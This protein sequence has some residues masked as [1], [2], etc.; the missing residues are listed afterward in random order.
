MLQMPRVYKFISVFVFVSLFF[1]SQRSY[2]DNV[3]DLEVL[4]RAIDFIQGGPSGAV[5]MFVVYDPD[6]PA[7]VEHADEIN[8]IGGKETGFSKV[9]LVVKKI[10]I[11]EL[12]TIKPKIIFITRGMEKNYPS[13]VLQAI[14]TSAVTV[15]TDELCLINGGCVIVT[16][17][18]PETD[19]LV[20]T[21]LA[22]KTRTEF[23]FAFTMM[24]TRK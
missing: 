12:Q 24:I 10:P 14:K 18:N 3:K 22:T 13:I 2:A 7:S 1:V 6:I 8:N 21:S 11:N 4:S 17:T 5:D 20:S 9:K 15:S 23:S 19:I 16:K